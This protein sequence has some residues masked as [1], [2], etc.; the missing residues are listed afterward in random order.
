[1]AAQT[2]TI[3]AVG[4]PNNIVDIRAGMLFP[5]P[6]R[7]LGVLFILTGIVTTAIEPILSVFLVIVGIGVVSAYEGTEIDAANNT[8][9]EYYSFL[10]VR[11]G[12]RRSYARID[13]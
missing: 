12:S 4:R 6:F 1:M 11:R 7:V 8:F 10:M 3:P 5:F 13:R 9:R 2:D